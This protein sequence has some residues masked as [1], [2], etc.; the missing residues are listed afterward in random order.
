MTA[1]VSYLGVTWRDLRGQTGRSKVW[2]KYS[3]ATAAGIGDS[4]LAAQALA[5]LMEDCSAG[6]VVSTSGLI[7][8][9]LNPSNLGVTGDFPNAE[10]KVLLT[11]LHTDNTLSHISIPAPIAGLFYSDLETVNLGASQISAL[12]GA[13]TTDDAGGGFACN[14]QGAAFSGTAFVAGTRIR[15]RFQRKTTIWTL[16]PQLSSPEE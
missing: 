11:A 10:D 5:V 1:I 14:K 8:A 12:W 15:R 3:N 2:Y 13:L 6:A 9:V 4:V 7:A 16:T